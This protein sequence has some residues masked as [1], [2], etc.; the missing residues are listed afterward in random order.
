MLHSSVFYFHLL[1]FGV[2][3][4]AFTES[5][6]STGA[7][8]I[9]STV[10]PTLQTLAIFTLVFFTNRVYS[11]F[12]ERF[13]DC[14]RT[15]GGVTVVTSLCTGFLADS[16]DSQAMAVSIMRY[17][18]AILNIYYM[19]ISGP[20]DANKYGTLMQRGLLTEAEVGLLS[21]NKSPGVVLYSWVCRILKACVREDRLTAQEAQ[22]IEENVSTVRGA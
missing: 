7:A 8:P 1:F 18:N 2:A 13:H 10:F 19:L 22:R 3:L 14:C 15:N 6:G 16:A 5:D 12:N 9:P 20:L 17:T 4:L 21:A 11:R